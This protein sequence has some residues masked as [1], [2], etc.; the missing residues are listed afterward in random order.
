MRVQPSINSVESQENLDQTDQIANALHAEIKKALKAVDNNQEAAAQALSSGNRDGTKELYL[1][2][3]KGYQQLSQ[4]IST[5]DGDGP[6]SPNSSRQLQ[7]LFTDSER[8]DIPLLPKFV[9][10]KELD[11]KIEKIQVQV[12]DARKLAKDALQIKQMKKASEMFWN[13]GTTYQAMASIVNFKG[14]QKQ[15][16]TVLL[17]YGPPQTPLL[18]PPKNLTLIEPKSFYQHATHWAARDIFFTDRI[19]AAGERRFPQLRHFGNFAEGFRFVTNKLWPAA[20]LGLMMH[21]FI[22]FGTKNLSAYGVTPAQIFAGTADSQ[23]I[24]TTYLGSDFSR[25]INYWLGSAIIAGVAFTSGLVLAIAKRGADPEILKKFRQKLSTYNRWSYGERTEIKRAALYWGLTIFCLYAEARLAE[26]WARK[27]MGENHYRIAESNCNNKNMTLQYQEAEQNYNCVICPWDFVDYWKQAISQ[28]CLN[29][30][31]S[32]P[33]DPEFILSHLDT[34]TKHPDFKYIDLSR[35]NFLSWTATQFLKLLE[36][37]KNSGIKAL[38]TFDFSSPFR[39][40]IFPND[41]RTEGLA[42]FFEKVPTNTIILKNQG[43]GDEKTEILAPAMREA[44]SI[45]YDGN[46]IT[47]KGFVVAIKNLHNKTPAV[48]FNENDIGD[49]GIEQGVPQ[50]PKSVKAGDFGDNKFGKK[51]LS[52]FGNWTATNNVTAL[53]LSH[54]PGLAQA[55]FDAFGKKIEGSQLRKFQVDRCA[56][57]DKEVEDFS[58]HF[59]FLNLEEFIVSNNPITNEGWMSLLQA[60]VNRTLRRLVV[61]RT[62]IDAEGLEMGATLLAK[63]NIKEFSGKQLPATLESYI[64][65]LRAFAKNGAEFFDG[66]DN[67]YLGD[68]F[69]KSCRKELAGLTKFILNNIKATDDG[70]VPLMKEV[71]AGKVSSASLADNLNI[72]DATL[73]AYAEEP[74]AGNIIELIL[75]GNNLGGKGALEAL[76]KKAQFLLLQNLVISRNPY[77][78]PKDMYSLAIN[79]IKNIPDNNIEDYDRDQ[80]RWLQK[81]AEPRT[82][83][84]KIKADDNFIDEETRQIYKI[85]EPR[86][87][88]SLSAKVGAAAIPGLVSSGLFSTAPAEAARTVPLTKMGVD[89]G[90]LFGLGALGLIVLIL[91]IYKVKK[92]LKSEDKFELPTHNS[93][94]SNHA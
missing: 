43:L 83:I 44:T 63:T 76:G 78:T 59:P 54:N 32:E 22:V 85:I 18:N 5:S 34:I 79:L 84:Q 67:P 9:P 26:I 73:L 17:Q 28:E 16:T 68:A 1:A 29:G 62:K 74:E 24:L 11:S 75:P 41:G 52:V 46:R 93:L 88:V 53:D 37:F 51:A 82:N 14:N 57:G 49:D 33:R 7:D 80:I 86:A 65:F 66:S 91:L 70:G 56:I 47:A 12:A 89:L 61:D 72:T 87:K 69:L 58:A 36:K 3:S 20:F 35:Q 55:D 39:N 64:T 21:D 92:S 15:L 13:L 23:Q 27:F 8:E 31:L 19:V 48:S 10:E 90:L 94:G 4:L 60:S 25:E 71:A 6:Q 30:L 81:N 38:E 2:I 45:I 42:N 40:Q 77:I 50:L